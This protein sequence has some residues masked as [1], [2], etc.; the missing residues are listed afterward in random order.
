MCNAFDRKNSP[1]C[2]SSLAAKER[3][4]GFGIL[5]MR[6]EER[7]QQQQTHTMERGDVATRGDV[8]TGPNQKVAHK[9]KKRGL[10]SKRGE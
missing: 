9:G 3:E 7:P 1:G 8:I 5:G 2:I 6:E 10:L 4:G